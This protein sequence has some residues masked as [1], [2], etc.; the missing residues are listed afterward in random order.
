MRSLRELIARWFFM[1]HTTGRYTSSPRKPVGGRSTGRRSS[2]RG[3]W[4]PGR[5]GSH[6]SL[7]LHA[8]LLEYLAPEPSGHV[9]SQVSGAAGVLGALNLLDAEVLLSDVRIRE[10]LDPAITPL[11]SLERHHLFPKS[12]LARQ[13][14]DAR[15][16][17]NAIANMVFVDWPENTAIGA[18]GPQDYWPSMTNAVPAERIGCNSRIDTGTT[19][20]R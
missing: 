5:T 1:A 15:N 16:Q 8:R 11:R 10:L 14:I 19:A 9:R 20:K 7:Q 18:R 2:R 12:Y 4:I 13:G 17:V 3:G 6:H